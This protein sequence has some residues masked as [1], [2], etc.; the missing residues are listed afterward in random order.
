MKESPI[1]TRS[2]DLLLWLLQHTRR[3]P[4][5]ERFRLAKRIEDHAFAFHEHIMQA[6]RSK[7]PVDLLIKADWLLD[8]LRLD[9]R[10]TH[11][12]QLT[13]IDQYHFAAGQMREI[14]CLLGGWMKSLQKT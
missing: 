1:F 13:A 14:G 8:L 5:N 10:L 9:I 2:Y 3:F 12:C 4:K 11:A 6:A 7:Q